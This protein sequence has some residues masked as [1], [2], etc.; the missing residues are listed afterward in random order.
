[1]RTTS[2]FLIFAI[3]SFFSAMKTH[4]ADETID[5]YLRTHQLTEGSMLRLSDPKIYTPSGYDSGWGSDFGI[6]RTS[7]V[8]ELFLNPAG[9]D[10]GKRE[11][12]LTLN[13]KLSYK[14]AQNK[15]VQNDQGKDTSRVRLSVN[16]DKEGNFTNRDAHVF[17]NA[18]QVYVEVADVTI[19]GADTT[20]L[21]DVVYFRS[22]ISVERYYDMKNTQVKNLRH[23]YLQKDNEVEIS[24]NDKK[25]AV[26]YDLEWTFVD[27]YGY[28]QG[29]VQRLS[30]SDVAFNFSENS[31]RIRT[32]SHHFRIPVVF[33]EGYLVYRV[34]PLAKAGADFNRKAYGPWSQ[35]EKGKVSSAGR[36][37]FTVSPQRAHEKD[38]MKWHYQASYTENGIRKAGVDY[39][40]GLNFKRQHVEQLESANDVL[41]S[42]QKYDH[43][44]R[45]ALD[46]LAAPS[47]NQNLGTHLKYYDAFNKN[48]Q[49]Q[50]YHKKDFDDLTG[51]KPTP[52]PMSNSSGAARYYSANNNSNSMFRDHLPK[53]EGYPFTQT[54]YIPDKSNDVR[55]IGKPGKQYQIG[56][57][58][59][60]QKFIGTPG[61]SELDRLFGSE[62]G[63]AK[64]YRKRITADENGQLKVQYLDEQGNVIAKALAG[65]KPQALEKLP[66]DQVESLTI[67]EDILK[68]RQNVRGNTIEA[69]KKIMVA[70]EGSR[71]SFKYTLQ[72]STFQRDLCEGESICLDGIYNLQIRLTNEC[73]D[74]IKDST[75]QIGDTR[76]IDEQCNDNQPVTISFSSGPLSVGSYMLTKKLQL[77]EQALD[78]YLDLFAQKECIQSKWDTI[79]KENQEKKDSI[80][81]NTGC[82]QYNTIKRTYEYTTSDGET[83]KDT[84]SEAEYQRL[85]EQ[86][87]NLCGSGENLCQSAYEALLRDISPGGQYAK[88]YDTTRQ[89]TDPSVH[90][91]SVLN[92]TSNLLPFQDSHWR[93]PDGHYKD[94]DG[95]ASYINLNHI[96]GRSAVV[97]ASKIRTIEGDSVVRPENLLYVSDFIH[98]WKD[99]WAQALV[100]YHPEYGY[101]LY[102]KQHP[103]S[104]NYDRDLLATGKYTNAADSGYVKSD[105]TTNLLDQD[106]FFNS[107]PALKDTMKKKMQNFVSSQG[108]TFSMKEIVIAMHN[109]CA[110]VQCGPQGNINLNSLKQC[111][112]NKKP[113]FQ[114]KDQETRRMEWSSFRSM[115]LYLK[116]QI[117]YPERHQFAI[118]KG[119]FNG[120][121]GVKDQQ[122]G[123]ITQ[124]S[125][126]RSIYNVQGSSFGSGGCLTNTDAYSEKDLRYPDGDDIYKY[127]DGLDKT[128]DPE[129]QLKQMEQYA[130]NVLKRN[131]NKCPV[132]TDMEALLNGLLSKGSISENKDATNAVAS[133][134]LKNQMNTGGNSYFSWEST[135]SGRELTGKLLAG[136]REVCTI[137]LYDSSKT[138]VNWDNIRMFTCLQHITNTNQY[139][140]TQKRNF[141]VRAITKNNQ[142]YWLEGV[143]SCID[144][145]DCDV[146]KFCTKNSLAGDLTTVF[147][148]AF[149]LYPLMR[150]LLVDQGYQQMADQKMPLYQNSRLIGE[151]VMPLSDA[152]KQQHNSPTRP[153]D[154]YWMVDNLSGNGRKLTAGIYGPKQIEK[155]LF[156]FTVLDRTKQFGKPFTIT[157]IHLNH[158]A[159]RQ[160]NCDATSFVLEV[161]SFSL[162][163]RTTMTGVTG[164]INKD[165]P[166]ILGDPYYIKVSNS[167]YTLGE[168][169]PESNC[170]DEAK[171]GGFDK[172]RSAFASDLP[173]SPQQKGDQYYTV[174]PGDPIDSDRG[175]DIHDFPARNFRSIN[176]MNVNLQPFN[177]KDTTTAQKKTTERDT[178]VT[179]RVTRDLS[180]RKSALKDADVPDTTEFI[181]QVQPGKYRLAMDQQT[182]ALNQ[183]ILENQ[184]SPEDIELNTGNDMLLR[185]VIT[186][187]S[188]IG[189]QQQRTGVVRQINNI[190]PL[191]PRLVKINHRMIFKVS[192]QQNRAVW[193]QTLETE[194]DN[195]YSFSVKVRSL[196]QDTLTGMGSEAEKQ[197]S[198]EAG[199]QQKELSYT[200]DEGKWHVLKGYFDSGQGQDKTL[201]L[202]FEGVSQYQ[203]IDH[204]KWAVDDIVI[205]PQ[206]CPKTGCCP[207]IFPRLPDDAIQNPCEA[208]KEMIAEANTDREFEEFLEDTLSGIESGYRKAVMAANES[209]TMTYTDNFYQYT[210]YYYDQS[211]K[212]IKTVKPEGFTP[213]SKARVSQVQNNREQSQN[214]P[215]YPNHDHVTTYKYNSYN[216]VVYTNSPD[217]GVTR[218][219]YDELGRQVASQDAAQAD[220]GN[221]YT[222]TFYDP[223]NRKVESGQVEAMSSLT[224]STANDYRR[225]ENWVKAG[226]RSQVVHKY[227]DEPLNATINGYFP[228]GQQNL[229]KRPATVVYE[230]QWDGSVSTYD[231]ATHYSYDVQGNINFLV[232]EN[233]QFPQP[234]QVKRIDYDFDVITGDIRK[235]TYQP[236]QKDQFIHKYK[237]DKD[238]RLKK[239]LTSR[240]ELHWE[241]EA[242]Y[243]Y[244]PHGKLARIELGERKVQGLDYAYTLQGWLKG[245][246]GSEL[247]PAA[248]AGKDGA[249]KG[250]FQNVA[251]DAFSMVLDY[252]ANDYQPAGGG[253]TFTSHRS[254]TLKNSSPGLYGSDV[255]QMVVN[256]AAFSNSKGLAMA[257]RYDQLGRLVKSNSYYRNNGSWQSTSDYEASFS[258]DANGNLTALTRE[259]DQ[260]LMD[261]LDY[262]Y[263]QGNNRIDHISDQVGDGRYPNDVDDQDQSNYRYDARGRLTQNLAE[264]I[265]NVR[266]SRHDRVRSVVKAGYG[267]VYSSYDATGLRV[268]KHH[269]TTDNKDQKLIRYV[270]GVNNQILAK[271]KYVPSEDSTYLT[272]Q[273][274]HGR[275]RLGT[276]S[277]DT[278]VQAMKNGHIRQ[279]RGKKQYEIK[280]H[281]DNV[282]LTVSDRKIP[283]STASAGNKYR[284]RIVSAT[285]YYPYGSQ[286]PGRNV[287][288]GK[289]AYGYQGKEKDDELQGA[290]NTYYFE[291]RIYDPRLGRWWSVDPLAQNNASKS[292]YMSMSG[293]PVNRIDKKGSQDSEKSDDVN[294]FLG[295]EYLSF[296]NPFSDEPIRYYFD[297][298][299][300]KRVEAIENKMEA[301][302]KVTNAMGD[303]K[304][305]LETFTNNTEIMSQLSD[306]KAKKLREAQDMLDNL[307][308]KLEKGTE[309]I[310]VYEDVKNAVTVVDAVQKINKLQQGDMGDPENALNQAKQFDRLFGSVGHFA[311]KLK[312]PGYSEFLG[313]FSGSSFFEDNARN[314]IP[315][316]KPRHQRHQWSRDLMSN[317]PDRW[318][319]IEGKCT[320][321]D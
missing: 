158:P 120:C 159:I 126:L 53:S 289:Y 298:V 44:G 146:E 48:Q 183:K 246:N 283:D 169:C 309:L 282:M 263:Q 164:T 22:S 134:D 132:E 93:N 15:V 244:Y 68:N 188:G 240:H 153:S 144:L 227:Y 8:L 127:V 37:V 177:Q 185:Q 101:Y 308:G 223:L 31:Q 274:I 163:Y 12:T 28:N 102:C 107:H 69:S 100:K 11:F 145:T 23:Q 17:S 265:Q 62:A 303:T 186:L 112:S 261:Q 26:W 305:A 10:F 291:E 109:G 4:G 86:Q 196:T 199:N 67:E 179:A 88:Y 318:Q 216:K 147:N 133:C 84:L 290:G 310:G 316:L 151:A 294:T 25:G 237:Y 75:V 160:D 234:H 81:C 170:P 273:Y 1:M 90:P 206:S 270:R 96:G 320:N 56:A 168:C 300:E 236:G 89:V 142:V 7:N 257:F 122:S 189:D 40:D 138:Q 180:I 6:K 292:P 95:S 279:I 19:Q 259:G 229:R 195:T 38:Q 284:P 154:Y 135:V 175:L 115:Y 215:V 130:E 18:H 110:A 217:Q 55:R 184:F 207:P 76:N 197:F 150:Q 21:T 182:R 50:P 137:R 123:S 230:D 295:A 264:D 24:W 166:F 243:Y 210:L 98:Y 157:E 136:Q 225:F 70:T 201:S 192:D 235:I 34:R 313:A 82:G 71:Y 269:N 249:N 92:D 178:A 173:Y 193:K 94:P 85:K 297:D 288:T 129:T 299:T 140:N 256:N 200:G 111:I 307:H 47:L 79:Y 209:M 276:Y 232:K 87:S 78:Q 211:G 214:N 149:G 106:P 272:D 83:R 271:Y 268:M 32:Q 267:S 54:Q 212:L 293:D 198:L 262:S 80:S 218:Y 116:R 59:A 121:I 66:A 221:V 306:K 172:G 148:K 118:N 228:G 65:D 222:Y 203:M 260:G 91:L 233:K 275:S 16:Y 104:N 304:Q 219:W 251:R 143:S 191:N 286:M 247:S 117:M 9:E 301:Y 97:D 60:V 3:I 187:G 14:D 155:C 226:S 58:H 208:K 252:N 141:K 171:N 181:R 41:V 74:V 281:L 125:T 254:G 248:D 99:S 35:P 77:N 5:T 152:L 253:Q 302:E 314:L 36:Q 105:G 311:S 43:H 296:P 119:Y 266:W 277:P 213:L 30:K 255:R 33:E 27:N 224:R 57:G 108:N 250:P 231:F 321:C 238:H 258:Y 63:Y 190:A 174:L 176:K 113:L 220:A 64:H 20:S 49:G 2:I 165:N 245:I 241:E 162:N 156:E 51:C 103:E 29:S 73:G 42:E 242:K 194:P 167:C 45:K 161:R 72:P 61:Q 46:I 114:N 139:Q 202:Q 124:L 312:L 204:Q 205:K 39:Y 285:G 131:C 319:K 13:L 287:S 315:G 128:F 280:D 239:I 52:K 278:T 317:D